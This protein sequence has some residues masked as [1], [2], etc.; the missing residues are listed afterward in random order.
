MFLTPSTTP[1]T[2]SFA[3]SATSLTLEITFS[4]APSLS[5]SLSPTNFPTPS[6]IDPAA[7]FNFFLDYLQLHFFIILYKLLFFLSLK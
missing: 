3:S 4:V 2:A 1:S 7:W 6:L 5:S